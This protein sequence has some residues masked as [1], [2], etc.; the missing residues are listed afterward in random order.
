MQAAGDTFQLSPHTQAASPSLHPQDL[1]SHPQPPPGHVSS[2]PPHPLLLVYL[3]PFKDNFHPIWAR[4]TAWLYCKHA[5]D[6]ARRPGASGQSIFI[7]TRLPRDH[8]PGADTP[9]C[10]LVPVQGSNWEGS[11]SVMAQGGGQGHH[12][13]GA[14]MGHR[15]LGA[16]F[17]ALWIT[18]RALGSVH[19]ECALCAVH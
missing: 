7:C 13:L 8:V 6:G 18:D 16:V 19:N 9:I 17:H 4:H 11:A 3:S 1:L 15:A 5:L 10:L 12:A 14:G 2:R